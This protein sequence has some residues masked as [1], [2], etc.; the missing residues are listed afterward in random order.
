V[1]EVVVVHEETKSADR[2][3]RHFGWPRVLVKRALA[4]A[5]AFPEEIGKA[6]TGETETAS[7]TG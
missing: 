3:A 5:K 2:T 1:W 6:G 4:C 7:V